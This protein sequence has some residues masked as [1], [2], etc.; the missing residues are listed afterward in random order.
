M[1]RQHA[2]T[3]TDKNHIVHSKLVALVDEIMRQSNA[4][5][6]PNARFETLTVTYGS[7][8][9]TPDSITVNF[10]FIPREEN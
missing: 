3:I 10:T 8:E 6:Y 5:D 7:K 9:Y 2:L 4:C 1:R